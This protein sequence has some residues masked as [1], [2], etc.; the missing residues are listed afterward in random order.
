MKYQNEEYNKA[1]EQRKRIKKEIRILEQDKNVK[2]YIELKKVLND[3]LYNEQ[4]NSCNH[5]LVYS[6]VYYNEFSGKSIKRC[7]CI[8]CGLDESLLD[9]KRE[10]LSFNSKIMYDFLKEHYGV[11][12]GYNT[13]N[14]CDL[15]LAKAIYFKIK[16]NYPNVNDMLAVKYFEIALDNIRNIKINDERKNSRARRLLL[17]SKFNKWNASDIYVKE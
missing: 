15:S 4:Y 16:D 2:K 13:D 5:V 7:G 12:E 8:K 17:K 1:I 11:I 6:K 9:K 14:M 3:N 10:E